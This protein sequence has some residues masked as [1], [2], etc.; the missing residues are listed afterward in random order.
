MTFEIG[1]LTPKHSDLSEMIKARRFNEANY[2]TFYKYFFD[3]PSSA[4]IPI[5]HINNFKI[6][7]STYPSKN[8]CIVYIGTD[9]KILDLFNFSFYSLSYSRTGL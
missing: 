6:V 1:K 8:S 3:N 9:I 5:P 7:S 4:Y 2:S